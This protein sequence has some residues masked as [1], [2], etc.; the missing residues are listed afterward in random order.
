MR[1][2]SQA[3][4]DIKPKASVWLSVH[5]ACAGDKTHVVHVGQ[6][7]GMLGTARK[8]NL[9]FAAEVLRVLMAQE[10]VGQGPGRGGHVKNLVVADASQRARRDVAYHVA[11]GLTRGDDNGRQAPHNIRGI[12]DMHERQS[13]ILL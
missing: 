1:Y 13:K 10:E 12:V 3:T 6:A 11:K 7:T 4:A 9:K 8:G 2:R 5:Q